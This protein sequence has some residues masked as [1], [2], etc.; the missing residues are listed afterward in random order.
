MTRKIAL[1][2]SASLLAAI[3]SAL[4]NA[5]E[6]AASEPTTTPSSLSS[7]GAA[8]KPATDIS[9][10]AL[11][12]LLKQLA[13]DFGE[14]RSLRA[15][16][17]QEQ[18]WSSLMEVTRARGV[19][20]FLRPKCIRFEISEPFRSVFVADGSHAAKYEQVKGKW[21]KLNMPES[22]VLLV[23]MNQIAT[24]LQ[25][26][27]DQQ[28]GIYEIHAQKAEC[29]TIILTPRNKALR[30]ILSSIELQLDKE[31][32]KFVSV[33]MRVPGGDYTVMK[34][35]SEKRNADLAV[36]LFDVSAKV[37]VDVD[38]KKPDDAPGAT[39]RPTDAA[40]DKGAPQRQ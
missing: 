38:Y 19:C 16:F 2:L 20:L 8:S 40:G 39:S 27:F 1:L 25:G 21:Q 22:E 23:V 24:W 12:K 15:E 34:F 33:T 4:W 32:K 28:N 14:I 9:G 11:T 7:A 37:P 6:V 36:G 5:T 26:N 35:S 13:K 10:E 17:V 18:H 29:V 3:S 31:N 30:D